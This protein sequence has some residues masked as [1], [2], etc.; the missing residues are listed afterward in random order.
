MSNQNKVAEIFKNYGDLGS[1][2][3]DP[4]PFVPCICVWKGA[5]HCECW[6]RGWKEKHTPSHLLD[7]EEVAA[8]W[9][10]ARR[11]WKEKEKHCFNEDFVKNI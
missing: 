11:W 6:K 4:V 7:W 10:E 5:T 9:E 1:D 2:L 3:N 8:P